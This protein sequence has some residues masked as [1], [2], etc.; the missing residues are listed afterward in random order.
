[1]SRGPGR[2]ERAIRVLF[3]A[4]PDLAFVT[5]ELAEHCYPDAKAIERK[6]QVSVLRAARSLAEKARALITQN[7]PDAIRAGLAE[8][9]AQLEALASSPR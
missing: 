3:D 7:D 9:A 5:D 1:M 2:I 6:H 4:N 8:I